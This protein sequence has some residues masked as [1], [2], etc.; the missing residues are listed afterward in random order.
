MFVLVVFAED[1]SAVAAA[2][3]DAKV[4]AF[5]FGA[6]DAAVLVILDLDFAIFWSSCPLDC[7]CWP[8]VGT[9]EE[10]LLEE[11]APYSEE[12]GDT[13]TEEVD[14]VDGEVQPFTGTEAAEDKPM[15]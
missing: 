11:H 10:V 14:K 15:G 13:L 3:D 2:E 1:L 12:V 5:D 8:T 7:C 4:V 9:E 6:P